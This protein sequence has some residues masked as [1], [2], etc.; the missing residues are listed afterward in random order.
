MKSFI[1]T[2]FLGTFSFTAFS[3]PCDSGYSC[4]S[5]SGKYKIE[6]Q[7]C[8]YRNRISLASFKI[9]D[10]EV[11]GAD[12]NKGWDGDSV[13]GFEINIPTQLEDAVEILSAEL[14]H[15]LNSG[16]LRIKYAESEPGPL[17]TVHI[18]NIYCKIDD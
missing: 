16:I 18:E 7:R 8:R 11:K 2:F 5:N 17:K 1:L 3:M 13:L 9:N 10:V 14:P 12:L 6:L 15:K 4:T